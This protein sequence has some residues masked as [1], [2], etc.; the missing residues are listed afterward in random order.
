MIQE[1]RDHTNSSPQ[2]ESH[3]SHVQTNKVFLEAQLTQERLHKLYAVKVQNPFSVY[4]YHVVFTA[5]F[6]ITF[7]KP[8]KGICDLSE[9]LKN[10]A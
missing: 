3:Y 1:V 4:T 7:H 8:E 5:D 2:L 6:S 10:K 9:T